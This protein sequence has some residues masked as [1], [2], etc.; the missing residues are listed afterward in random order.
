MRGCSL[1]YEGLESATPTMPKT[2]KQKEQS[3]ATLDSLGMDF[4]TQ[5]TS[6]GMPGIRL[7]ARSGRSARNERMTE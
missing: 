6:L 3:A 5:P 7:S 2:R 4:S 1:G